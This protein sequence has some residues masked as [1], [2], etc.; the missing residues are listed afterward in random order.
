M[1][2]L[3][4]QSRLTATAS[5]TIRMTDIE[6]GNFLSARTLAIVIPVSSTLPKDGFKPA[7]RERAFFWLFSAAQEIIDGHTFGRSGQRQ[8]FRMGKR[9]RRIVIPCAPVLFHGSSREFKVLGLAFVGSRP[10][11]ELDDVIERRV[12][13]AYQHP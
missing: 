7:L 1:P 4:Y 6:N 13:L 11:H 12:G 2:A 10:V 8:H 5:F 3:L 9:R